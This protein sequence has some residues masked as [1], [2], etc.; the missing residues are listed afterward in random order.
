MVALGFGPSLALRQRRAG[1]AAFGF[2]GGVLPAG[3]T[4]VRASAATRF[5]AAGLL[6]SEAAN[7]ARFDYDQA[8][9]ALRG[10]L[11]ESATTNSVQGSQGPASGFALG[12]ADLVLTTGEA[13]PDGSATGMKLA[14]SVGGTYAASLANPAAAGFA[15]FT[16]ATTY[17]ASVWLKAASYGWARVSRATSANAS[18]S[19]TVNLAT[20]A[21][22]TRPATGY[23]WQVE[24]FARGW[25]R[26]SLTASAIAGPV[27][28][29]RLVVYMTNYAGATDAGVTTTTL[30]AGDAI[31]V[32]WPQWEELGW[33]SSAVPTPAGAGASRAADVLTLNWA[34]LGVADGAVVVRYTF[35]DGSTQDVATA[36]SGGSAVVPTPLARPRIVCAQLV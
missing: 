11:V 3:A 34:S 15:P 6:V 29:Q 7:V 21:Y 19:L 27:S 35:D 8:T 28:G 26:V 5:N 33:A 14:A 9:L 1:G 2:A 30:A 36:V 17:T 13:A 20:G 23:G 31:C 10:L 24:A 12:N 32:A 4:L 18:G 16:T 22:S 25:W